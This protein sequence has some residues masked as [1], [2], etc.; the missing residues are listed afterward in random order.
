MSLIQQILVWSQ[1]LPAWQGD[2]IARLLKHETLTAADKDDLYA[3]L[4]AAHGIPDPKGRI[5]KPLTASLVPASLGPAVNVTLRAIKDLRHV[6]AL[7]E[8]HRL[9][10]GNGGMTIIYGDNGS[11]KSGYSR[12]LKRACR[13]RDQAEKI[14]PNANL[15]ATGPQV[16]EA[17]F[18][19]AV[20]GVAEMVHWSD[21]ATPPEVLSS[22]AIFD[23]RCA[24]AYLDEEDDFSYVPYG[25]DIFDGL[26]NLLIDLKSQVAAERGQ[27]AVDLSIFSSLL[28]N[29][30]TGELV[31]HLSEATEA[32]A[33]MELASLTPDELAQHAALGN[34]LKESD[35]KE[36]ATQL[37]LQERRFAALAQLLLQRG[38]AVDEAT[39]ANI[40]SRSGNVVAAAA[41]AKLAAEQ[42]SAGSQLLPG[43][44]GDAWRRLF[45]AARAFAT[46][47]HPGSAFPRLRED[48]PCPLCQQPLEKG[49][50]LL[51]R[52]QGFIEQTAERQLATA[53]KQ[54]QELYEPF[55]KDSL[56]LNLD[57]PAYAE[58][59]IIDP[60]L[61]AEVRAYERALIDRQRSVIAAVASGDWGEV[62][63]EGAS[64]EP[65]LKQIVGD[66]KIQVDALMK[67]SDESQRAALRVQFEELDA[68]VR[69]QSFKGA[70][71]TAIGK[72][73]HNAKLEKCEQS[74]NTRGISLKAAELTEQAVS[75]ELAEALN[76]EFKA[77]SV[78]G[79]QVKLE[80]RAHKGKPLHKLKLALPKA[81]SP[82]DILSE[83]EQ[84]SIAIGSFL[85][86]VNLGGGRS[87]IVFDDPVSSLDHLRREA[88]ARR[89]AVEAKQRQVIVFTHCLYFAFLLDEE[90]KLQDVPVLMQTLTRKA[91]GFG[92]TETDVP[93]EGKPTAKRVSALMQQQVEIAKLFKE[94]H[95]AERKK[96]TVEAYTLL[97]NAWERA[98]EE[99]LFDE[100]V[101]R[102]RK[103]ISTTRLANVL[104]EDGDYQQVH[105][106]MTRCSNYAHDKAMLGGISIP[107]PDELLDDIKALEAW[108]LQVVKRN[109][110]TG[111]SRKSGVTAAKVEP[112]KI[113]AA[114]S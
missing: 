97:R 9:A 31:S 43:T 110:I 29:T 44:G 33:V 68:R 103:G 113:P 112:H 114:A 26:A 86:E 12:V 5:A 60:A 55:A 46:E 8:H 35:P 89:L 80:S 54:L 94:G 41:A 87:A 77:L 24:R 90:A 20:N 28:G 50:A 79:L 107:T 49:A 76:R 22:I 66:L 106:G 56:A 57:E 62:T 104:V 95:E 93:F 34:S 38:S 19:V 17:D 30:K 2:A 85:A 102:F 58:L 82:K 48:S 16:A 78:G 18:E 96:A 91:G 53:R 73:S 37:R 32:S 65:R 64:P 74:L 105:A 10:F 11:G 88:V 71:L 69:L 81:L 100:V 51:L 36:K 3:L 25:L 1:G 59:E 75:A 6:N 84:R 98:V 99:V 63:G 101:M 23:T 47:S 70:I 21:A 40:K 15:K 45:E 67:A 72:L 111:K 52:F 92:M 27:N 83:G 4:K 14:H 7:A 39:I 109:V 42:F 13:A 61:A 108:R